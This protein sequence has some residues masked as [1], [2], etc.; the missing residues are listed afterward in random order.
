MLLIAPSTVWYKLAFN[1]YE[2]K[3]L[4]YRVRD[5]LFRFSAGAAPATRKDRA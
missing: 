1:H 4:S 2:R 5:Q 3:A